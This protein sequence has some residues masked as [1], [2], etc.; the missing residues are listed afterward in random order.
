MLQCNPLASA[1]SWLKLYESIENTLSAAAKE[2]WIITTPCIY[3]TYSVQSMLFCLQVV[4]S[5]SCVF[6]IEELNKKVTYNSQKFLNA[7]TYP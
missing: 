7:S 6:K 3:E 1:L 2:G 5:E 4:L